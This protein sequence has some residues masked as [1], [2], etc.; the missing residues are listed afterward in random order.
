MGRALMAIG[1]GW[2]CL[3]LV[4]PDQYADVTPGPVQ[5]ELIYGAAAY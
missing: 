4:L 5:V 2:R 3:P 1:I